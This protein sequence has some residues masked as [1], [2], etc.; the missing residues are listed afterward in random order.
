[1]AGDFCQFCQYLTLSFG[2]F[3]WNGVTAF[4]G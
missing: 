4:E 1:M 3:M 2:D